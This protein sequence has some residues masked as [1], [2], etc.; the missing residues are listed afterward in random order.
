MRYY[1]D[2][3]ILYNIPNIPDR[4]MA[5]SY[6]SIL[7]LVE[8]IGGM[9]DDSFQRRKA[10][11][12]NIIET[13][14]VIDWRLPA[15][16]RFDAFD[17]YSDLYLGDRRTD[18]IREAMGICIECESLRDFNLATENIG[19]IG[20]KSI[21]DFDKDMSASFVAMFSILNDLIKATGQPSIVNVEGIEYQIATP[22]D[23]RGLYYRYPEMHREELLKSTCD[24]VKLYVDSINSSFAPAAS[25]E[26]ILASYNG[27]L[28]HYLTAYARY[29]LN[30]LDVEELPA[31]NDSQDIQHLLYLNS[32][33]ECKIVTND[34]LYSRLL[35]ENC[36][37]MK[38]FLAIEV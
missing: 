6:G 28:A 30:K 10:G 8:I 16:V 32:N 33:E 36:L 1:L 13:D 11:I 15:T 19:G 2:T 3:N 7:G 34:K 9:T 17:F 18:F 31:R 37:T 21:C 25:S 5:D 4:K 14:L 23:L 29:G 27:S 22:K 26:E 20:L 35:K 38:E 12:R 24:G